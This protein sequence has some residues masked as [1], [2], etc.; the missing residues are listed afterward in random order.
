M[1]DSVD[2]H[3]RAILIFAWVELISPYVLG[4]IPTNNAY[5]FACANFNFLTL[6]M[7]MANKPTILMVD[8]SLLTF[9]QMCLQIAAMINNVFIGYPYFYPKSIKIIVTITLIRL[10][11]PGKS[12]GHLLRLPHWLIRIRNYNLVS[13][14]DKKVHS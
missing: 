9:A 8:F 12:D 10:L 6:M 5:F 3:V 7:I 14:F 2:S 1:R 11:W 4:L 13:L